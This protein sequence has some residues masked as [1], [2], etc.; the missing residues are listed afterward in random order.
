MVHGGPGASCDYFKYHAELFSHNVNV[1]LFDEGGVRRS[2]AINPDIFTF[3][4]LIDDMDDIRKVLDIKKWSVLGHSFGG[5]LALL[6]A[7][8][9][10]EH[11]E[12]VVFECPS[13]HYEDAFFHI[14]KAVYDKLNERGYSD[15]AARI[16]VMLEDK[17]AKIMDILAIVPGHI[18]SELYHPFPKNEKVAALDI[19]FTDEENEKTQ[20]HCGIVI[21]NNEANENHLPKLKNLYMPALLLLGEYDFV[22]SPKQQ[23]VFTR[24]VAK[25]EIIILPNC[26]HNLH[27]EVPQIFVET[28]WDFVRCSLPS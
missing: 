11:T 5:L 17:D 10:H 26:G 23:D 18:V 9:Y 28:V 15:I 22:C 27:V 24:N 25:G 1:V 21:S 12:T 14:K 7:V 16:A 20:I 2:D 3:Q 8:K 19:D 4:D 6:Y 13:F